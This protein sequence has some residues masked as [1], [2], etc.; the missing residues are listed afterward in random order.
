MLRPLGRGSRDSSVMWFVLAVLAG[1][2]VVLWLVVLCVCWWMFVA[3]VAVALVLVCC[4]AVLG[5][6]AV[7]AVAPCVC[8]SAP[9]VVAVVVASSSLH[10]L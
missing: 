9:V 7:G 4:G 10:L 6:Q 8:G 1:V 2:G 3:A 5:R